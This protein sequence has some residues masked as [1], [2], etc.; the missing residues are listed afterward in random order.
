MKQ[1]VFLDE[2]N[3]FSGMDQTVSCREERNKN[4]LEKMKKH[5]IILSAAGLLL[6]SCG[7]YTKYHPATEVPEGLYGETLTDSLSQ[8]AGGDTASLGDMDW[9]QFF[10][11]SHLQALIEKGLQNNTD[12]LSAQLRVKEAEATLLSAKL[13]Y[14]PSFALSPQGTVSSFDKMK[15]TQTYQLP[16]AA[17]WELDIF[18]RLRNAKRQSQALLAQSQDY[19]QAVRAQLIAGIANT[20]YTLL[21]LDDQLA[22]SRETE[23][24]WSETVRSARA[25]MEAG[26]Y[27]EAGVSQMEAAYYQVKASVLDLEDQLNQVRNSLSLLLAETPRDYERGKLG[28][29]RFV[30]EFPV[31]I[32][33]RM[34]AARPDVRSAERS[35]EAAFYGANAARSAFYPSI[36]LS[37]SAGWTN[38]AGSMIVNPGKFVASAVG[39]LTQL[40]FARGQLLGQFKI[41]KA[42]QEEASLAFQQ[43]LL[44]AGAEVN[45]ALTAWQ[46]AGDK[47]RLLDKQ[48]ASLENALRSTS[49]LMDYGNT[50]YLE[51]LTARQS[52]LS[53]RLSQTAHRFAEIQSLITLYQALGGGQEQEL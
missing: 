28:E 15:A 8:V 38:A 42:R 14:L 41:A 4:R 52:L 34:L 47:S 39:S 7:V 26:M 3:S 53:A 20:Y 23:E 10:T 43:A 51:V 25:M 49:L 37:G 22:I 45:D 2:T 46:T 29:Q 27:N 21:M 6:S 44:N 31:G 19:R 40:L 33:L 24:A 48:V 17:S 5:I 12:Y 1:T 32:P 36:T 50:T 13:A 30:R 16:V 18:G 35:L 11:D 9:R